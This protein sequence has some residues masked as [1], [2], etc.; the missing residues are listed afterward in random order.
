MT[1]QRK[2]G[3][4]THS[5]VTYP[6]GKALR[7]GPWCSGAAL[8]VAP[9]AVASFPTT[10]YVPAVSMRLQQCPDCAGTLLS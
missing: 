1:T 2:M 3:V 8:G 9:A 10:I 5:R 4:T 7:P 6:L